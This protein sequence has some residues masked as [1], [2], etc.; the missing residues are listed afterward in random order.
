[1]KTVVVEIL[2]KLGSMVGFSEKKFLV[3][4]LA[5]NLYA[6]IKK[7]SWIKGPFF[8]FFSRFLRW[9]F[10]ILFSVFA[11]AIF[12]VVL[13]YALGFGTFYTSRRHQ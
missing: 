12:F 3:F 9:I 10:L 2:K 7:N 5:K 4:G 8:L 1:M 11:S 6:C 13:S